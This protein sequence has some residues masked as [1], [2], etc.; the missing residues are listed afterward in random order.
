MSHLS[1]AL[2]GPAAPPSLTPVPYSDPRARRLI[3]ALHLGQLATYGFADDPDDTPEQ[4]FAPPHGLF[5]IAHRHEIPVG[6]GGFRLLDTHTA[7]IK[8]MYVASLAR[9]RGLGRRILEHLEHLA[10]SSGASRIILE[11]GYRNSAALALYRQC[12][13]LPTPPYVPGRNPEV[14]RAMLKVLT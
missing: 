8:R 2:P 4:Q 7:E 6:C 1:P 3:Q 9:G 14:N 12:G 5:V 11:T 10:A 13:F